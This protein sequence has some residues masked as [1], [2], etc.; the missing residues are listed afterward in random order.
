MQITSKLADGALT[1]EAN[2]EWNRSQTIA[3]ASMHCTHCHGLGLQKHGTYCVPCGCVTRAIFK[4]CFNRFKSCVT[5]DKGASTVK[6]ER[7][8]MGTGRSS[9]M[10]FGR[11]T[12]EYIADFYLICKRTLTEAEW[13]LF[14]FHYLL[15][16][17][18][19]L[20][21]RHFTSLSREAFVTMTQTMEHKLGR[22]FRETA[23]FA[24]YPLDEYFSATTRGAAIVPSTPLDTRTRPQRLRPPMRPVAVAAA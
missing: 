2:M 22:V 4:A 19:N 10:T 6:L 14:R 8:G 5:K 12:E 24:L 20:L 23:P 18:W 13:D 16:A 7:L 11:K 17:D 1:R 15:G 9:H 21:Q 3:L